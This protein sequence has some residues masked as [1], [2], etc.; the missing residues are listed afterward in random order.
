[1]SVPLERVLEVCHDQQADATRSYCLA[2]RSALT[3]D[4]RAPLEASELKLQER[5]TLISDSLA[6][7]EQKKLFPAWGGVQ[8]ILAKGLLQTEALWPSL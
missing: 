3:D 1:M 2:V 7:V 6:R 8:R 4:G 5:L